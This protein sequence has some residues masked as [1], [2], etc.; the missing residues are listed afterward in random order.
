MGVDGKTGSRH[1]IFQVAND[2]DTSFR[3]ECLNLHWFED[4]KDAKIKIETWRKDYNQ[5]RPHRALN[6]LS[7]NEYAAQLAA[8]TRPLS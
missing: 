1:H 2:T 3:D 6:N 8:K 4:Y 7:P 5:S